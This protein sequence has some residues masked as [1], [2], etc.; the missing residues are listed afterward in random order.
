MAESWKVEISCAVAEL[1][2]LK[3]FPSDPAART[4]IMRLLERMVPRGRVD[5]LE[6]LISTMV[7]RVG[8]W[9]G[10]VELRGVFCTRFKPADGVEATCTSTL[11]FTP[12]EMEMKAKVPELPQGEAR[13]LLVDVSKELV[14]RR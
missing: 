12:E 3:F 11:G 13:R 8:V 9:N 7:D 1:S 5:C 6:W 4:A 14:V 10:P 2:I